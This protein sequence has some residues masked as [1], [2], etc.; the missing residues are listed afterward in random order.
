MRGGIDNKMTT[1]HR[2]RGKMAQPSIPIQMNAI[3]TAPDGEVNSIVSSLSYL[4]L[5]IMRDANYVTWH[6]ASED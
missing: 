6:L 4:K 1:K 5:L 2:F 3:W